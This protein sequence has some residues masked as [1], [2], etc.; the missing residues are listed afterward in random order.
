MKTQILI[1][2]SDLA[3]AV[4][5]FFAHLEGGNFR[6]YRFVNTYSLAHALA[7]KPYEE[8]LTDTNM[9]FPDGKPIVLIAR[10]LGHSQFKQIRGTDFFREVFALDNEV[11]L[12]RHFFLGTTEEN[13]QNIR[14]KLNLDYP[15]VLVAGHLD[16]GFVSRENPDISYFIDEI[17]KSG[18]NIVWV[19][20][21]SPLQDLVAAEITSR[22]RIT[23]LAVGAAFDFYSGVKS[24]APPRI[25]RFGLEWIYRFLKEPR[26]LFLRYF[27]YSPR[28]VLLFA[29]RRIKFK[30]ISEFR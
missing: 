17:A 22:H 25:I 26:R 9:N 18:A 3:S 1:V 15:K 7:V 11:S 27:F 23:T 28:F 14:K 12:G 29:M 20:L 24:E 16:P 6:S 10:I 30:K 2:E 13:L 8:I 5:T 21:G 4:S 19:G